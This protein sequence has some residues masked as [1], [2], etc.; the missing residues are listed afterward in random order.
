MALFA[1][2]DDADSL[3]HDERSD[4]LAGDESSAG[5]AGNGGSDSTVDDA[6]LALFASD[7]G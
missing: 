1:H 7:G 5:L 6:N 2:D 3:A 4:S